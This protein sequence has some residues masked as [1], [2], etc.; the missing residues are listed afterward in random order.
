MLVAIDG[1]SMNNSQA[2]LY[3]SYAHYL[4]NSSMSFLFLKM[5]PSMYCPLYF[6]IFPSFPGAYAPFSLC[7][8][9]EFAFQELLEIRVTLDICGDELFMSARC[10]FIVQFFPDIIVHVCSDVIH[11]RFSDFSSK[12]CHVLVSFPV[13]IKPPVPPSCRTALL[14]I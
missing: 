1:F 9:I 2:V 13:A 3:A 11:I 10:N 5:M 12:Y 8:K 7:L 6:F 14:L 4:W